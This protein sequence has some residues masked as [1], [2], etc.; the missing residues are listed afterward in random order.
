MLFRS[1]EERMQEATPSPVTVE[2][3]EGITKISIN[4]LPFVGEGPTPV[5]AEKD[6]V[7][8]FEDWLDA[9]E[10]NEDFFIAWF[11]E[12]RAGLQAM[13]ALNEQSNKTARP[14]RLFRRRPFRRRPVKK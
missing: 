1:I 14:L 6:F 8:K 5:E 4:G 13:L 3:A 10:E 2:S 11:V 7:T 9:S 12:N